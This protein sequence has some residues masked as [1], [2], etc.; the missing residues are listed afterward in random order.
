MADY[1]ILQSSDQPTTSISLG[2]LVIDVNQAGHGFI[3]G[4]AVYLDTTPEWKFADSA[5]DATLATHMVTSSNDPLFSATTHGNLPWTHGLGAAGTKLYLDTGINEGKLTAAAPSAPARKQ[6][7][8]TV[9]DATNVVMLNML[10]A[11]NGPASSTDTALARFSGTSGSALQDSLV[12]IDG[13]GKITPI[14]FQLA[15]NAGAG[16][17]LTSDGSGLGTWELPTA[18]IHV[19]LSSFVF[20]AIPDFTAPNSYGSATWASLATF[21]FELPA[22][23]TQLTSFDVKFFTSAM[24]TPATSFNCAILDRQPLTVASTLAVVTIPDTT[25]NTNTASEHLTASYNTPFTPS[26][27]NVGQLG[28]ELG[29]NVANSHVM[30]VVLHFA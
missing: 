2:Q 16:K 5:S 3:V 29:T 21:W 23:T 13:A 19:N 28:I 17:V 10:E 22:G 27:T 30:S 26:G 18:N 25:A 7:V 11:V 4:D 24:V 9:K 1:P 20:S 8:A 6:W 15:A 12:L 14:T